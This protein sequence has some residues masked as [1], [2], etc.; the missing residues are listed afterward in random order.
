MLLFIFITIVVIMIVIIMSFAIN[1]KDTAINVMIKSMNIGEKLIVK[2][3]DEKKRNGII[4][5]LP[6]PE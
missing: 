6:F 3:P 5:S 2:T 1:N 4:T